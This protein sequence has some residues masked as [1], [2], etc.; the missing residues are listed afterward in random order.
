MSPPLEWKQAGSAPSKPYQNKIRE[1]VSGSPEEKNH[2]AVIRKI[3]TIIS[4]LETLY[5]KEL[6]MYWV[7]F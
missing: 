2:T 1:G 6:T 3:T 7:L 4:S 5:S